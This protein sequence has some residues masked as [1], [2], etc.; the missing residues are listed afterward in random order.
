MNRHGN[1]IQ[2]FMAGGACALVGALVY[3]LVAW[4]LPQVGDLLLDLTIFIVVSV[5]S[6]TLVGFLVFEGLYSIGE[7]LEAAEDSS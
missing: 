6:A 4:V 2:Y 5:L 7:W 3:G 1:V